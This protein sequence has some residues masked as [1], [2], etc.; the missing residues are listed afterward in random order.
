MLLAQLL[1]CYELLFHMLFNN[2]VFYFFMSYSTKALYDCLEPELHKLTYHIIFFDFVLIFKKY[3][4][5]T[6]LFKVWKR[7]IPLLGQKK[8]VWLSSIAF[9]E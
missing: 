2:I 1:F 9:L 4:K 3:I 7:T 5:G 6:A 8:I